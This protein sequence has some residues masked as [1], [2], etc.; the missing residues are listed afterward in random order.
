MSHSTGCSAPGYS[1]ATSRSSSE[2]S[3]PSSVTGFGG[4]AID[5]SALEHLLDPLRAHRRARGH[6]R[7][8]GRH[9]HGH[10]DLDEVAEE[11]DQRA[12]LHLARADAVAADPDRGDARDVEDEHHGREHEGHEPA[13]LQRGLGEVVVGVAE[14]LRLVRLA[15][16]RPHDA[17]PGDLLAQHLV[18]AVDP[19]LHLLELRHHPHDHE[20]DADDE[21][22][23]AHEQEQ[24]ERPVLAHG[25]DRAA[26]DRD[27]RGDEAACRP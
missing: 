1:K 6:D 12:D 15:D 20:P 27:R 3:R 22:R 26:D 24:R 5:G 19:L 11:R 21:D 18:D 13:G 14:A 4:A 23:H 16:E 2:L 9:H 7:D 17:H 8:E 10:E 25:H